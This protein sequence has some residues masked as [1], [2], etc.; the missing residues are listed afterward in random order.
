MEGPALLAALLE[1]ADDVGLR[2]ER[3]GAQPALD[4]LSPGSSAVC[5]LRGATVVFLSDS[6]PLATRVRTLARGLR[7]HSGDALEERFLAPAL[8]A[9]LDA[10]GE[11]AL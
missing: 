3:V 10:A 5:R 4:G 1:L 9:C 8:R 2:V 7:E 11:N 6:D